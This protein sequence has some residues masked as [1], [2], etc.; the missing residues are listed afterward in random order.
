MM[1]RRKIEK[2][3]GKKRRNAYG[4]IFKLNSRSQVKYSKDGKV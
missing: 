4:T 1:I 2:P 3:G